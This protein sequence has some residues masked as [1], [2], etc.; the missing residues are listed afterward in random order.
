M[1]STIIQYYEISPAVRPYLERIC[2]FRFQPLCPW[3]ASSARM[4]T[5][6]NVV[7]RNGRVSSGYED[8]EELFDMRLCLA[9]SLVTNCL[10]RGL[11]CASY[12]RNVHAAVSESRANPKATRSANYWVVPSVNASLNFS[13]SKYAYIRSVGKRNKYGREL[14]P[15]SSS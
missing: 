9:L 15:L 6:V 3:P 8:G 7:Q 12:L 10:V 1:H 11:F 13:K 14:V 5:S 4:Q 2:I